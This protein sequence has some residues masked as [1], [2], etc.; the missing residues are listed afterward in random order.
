MTREE[1]CG[2]CKWHCMQTRDLLVHRP[3]TP[4]TSTAD[5]VVEWF[6]NNRR[7]DYYT[8][9]TAY[10]DVCDEYEDK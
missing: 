6:C 7:S 9:F 3:N 1:C 2:T 5:V 10:D 8:D 4:R